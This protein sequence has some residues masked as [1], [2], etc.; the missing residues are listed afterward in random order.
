MSFIFS[1]HQY[2]N[3]ENTGLIEIKQEVGHYDDVLWGSAVSSHRSIDCLLNTLCGHTSKNR[4]SPNYC[5]LWR[6]CPLW[7]GFPHKGPVTRKKYFHVM[8]PP[9]S[10]G[11]ICAIE[12]DF[13]PS[14]QCMDDYCGTPSVCW[15]HCYL[16]KKIAMLPGFNN[17]YM[18]QNNDVMICYNFPSYRPLLRGIHWSPMDSLHKGQWRGALIYSLMCPLRTGWTSIGVAGELRR[19]G[20]VHVTSVW[21]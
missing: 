13:S 14:D 8:T 12:W 9:W 2:V 21:W 5:P 16:I 11:V 10:P 4:Q 15:S 19:H 7:G 18:H 1:P 20:D 3:Q 6:T 17:R